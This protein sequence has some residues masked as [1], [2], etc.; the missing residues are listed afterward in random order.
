MSRVFERS[1]RDS[2]VGRLRRCFWSAAA[3]LAL[4]GG[5][6]AANAQADPGVTHLRIEGE[7]DLGALALF[8][9]AVRETRAAGREQIVVELDTPGGEIVL[10]RQIANAINDAVEG[11][12]FVA[13]W[14]NDQ[15][16]SAGV[17]V[18]ISCDKVYMRERASIGSSQIVFFGLQDVSDNYREKMTSAVRSTFRAAAEAR[19]RSPVLAEAMV[20]AGIEVVE[21]R[22]DGLKELITGQEW[23]DFILSSDTPERMRTICKR[24]ELLNLTASEA[25]E[26]G[27]ADA[28]AESLGEVLEKI[29]AGGAALVTVR[30]SR[31][32]EILGILN[33]LQFVLL[34]AGLVLAFL[35]LKMPGFGL[36]GILSVACFTLLF[37]ARY[38]VGLADIPHI[39]LAA[40]GVTLIAV[41]LF[42]V[43]GILWVGLLGGLLLVIGLI[44]GQLG[45]GFTLEN[46]IDREILFDTTLHLLL[47]AFAAFIAVLLL[48]RFLPDTPIL[49][50]FVLRSSDRDVFGAAVPESR[51]EYGDSVQVGSQGTAITDLRPVGKIVLDSERSLE[52]EARAAGRA[53]GSG[54]RVR[55]VELSG[56]RLVVEPDS[57]GDAH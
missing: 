3:L 38:L 26:F 31:S 8:Q 49:R 15:A 41:E 17:L 37:T 14:V 42:V 11:G 40:L 52:Y 10:M 46:P 4:L 47:T 45:P 53:I 1:V 50:R 33:E 12:L 2:I 29:G 23:D 43:P 34:A 22:R 27:F 21:V 54:T 32:E 19:G 9:R 57:D 18:A 39:V 7:L 44:F 20:D 36:P 13:A 51:G 55:V 28:T 5:A 16:L 48:S 56:G 35:E 24:G 6:R 30:R 25:V